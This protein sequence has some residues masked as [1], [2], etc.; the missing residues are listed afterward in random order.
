MNA[1]NTRRNISTK[2]RALQYG[3]TAVAIID[4]AAA[5]AGVAAAAG[6]AAAAAAAR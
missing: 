5:A 1:T 3:N 6:A 4:A 2:P